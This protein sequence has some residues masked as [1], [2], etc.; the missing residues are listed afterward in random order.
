MSGN[1]LTPPDLGSFK[2]ETFG[3]DE[4][5]FNISLYNLS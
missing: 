3:I 1:T 2:V 5:V 4:V